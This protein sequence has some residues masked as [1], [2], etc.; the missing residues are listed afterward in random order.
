ME[1][2][3]VLEHVDPVSAPARAEERNVVSGIC[4]QAGAATINSSRRV[5]MV[6]SRRPGVAVLTC[7][8]RPDDDSMTVPGA[9][10]AR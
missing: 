10:L 9:A 7:L 2:A 1:D 3:P 8:C 5:R 6:N 4:A